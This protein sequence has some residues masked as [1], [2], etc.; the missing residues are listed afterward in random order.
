MKL[1]LRNI[2]H[3]ASLSEE[4]QCYSGT[5]YLDGKPVCNVSNHGHGGCDMQH[6]TDREAQAR[7]EAHFKAMPE[8]DT[9]MEL[10]PGKPFM[11]QPD[12][13][14]W[15]GQQLAAWLARRDYKRVLSKKVVTTDGKGEWTWKVKPAD[16]G[17][18][19]RNSEGQMLTVRD[20]VLLQR[21]GLRIVN[22]FT[23]AELEAH[24]AA[25]IEASEHRAVA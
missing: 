3:M 8:R 23:E 14:D 2:K 21:P 24:I 20:H 1:E 4:T 25:M 13:E 10:E 15:C 11:V 17:K 9:G 12:L 19:M 7:I 5:V 6:W 22:E 18:M 16:L